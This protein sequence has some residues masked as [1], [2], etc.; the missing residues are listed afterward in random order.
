[1]RRIIAYGSANPFSLDDRG[2]T[3]LHTA[4]A[5]C[6]SL[7][8]IRPLLLPGIPLDSRNTHDYTPLSFTPL[9]DNHKVARFFLSE[10]ANINNVDKDGDTPLKEA[11]R[12]NAH[13][14][15]RL[16]LDEGAD[17]R[18]VNHRGWTV[19]HFAAA[20]GGIETIQI[21]TSSC[22]RG[23][24]IQARNIQGNMPRDCLFERQH[25][26]HAVLEAFE[27]LLR[28]V[29]L[30]AAS[31]AGRYGA[32]KYPTKISPSSPHLRPSV[33]KHRWKRVHSS[34]RTTVVPPDPLLRLMRG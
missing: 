15:L 24:D 8:L 10:G 33:R 28:S 3:L 19:L 1:L 2:A 13:N 27:S 34:I 22:L 30:E 20:C 29:T 5:G 14:C 12:L 31:S 11:I 6:D 7:P 4:A 32:Q 18:T 17:V 26:P 9:N 25:I 16:F 23:L 21:L